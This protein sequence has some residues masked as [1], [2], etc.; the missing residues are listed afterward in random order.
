MVVVVAEVIV[1]AET[2]KVVVVVAEVI[3]E[4]EVENV[5]VVVAEV[6]KEAEVENVVVVVAEVIVEAQIGF[7]RNQ[8]QNAAALQI[9]KRRWGNI[10]VGDNCV[11]ASALI[12]Y[13]PSE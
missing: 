1:E 7:V 13:G 2:K 10:G 8:G 3:K 6:I 9:F 5:V 11:R 12:D 4:A